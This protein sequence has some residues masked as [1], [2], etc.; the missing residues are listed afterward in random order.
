[1]EKVIVFA[2][3]MACTIP[4]A[5]LLCRLRVARKR[6]ISFGT[7]ALSAFVATFLWLAFVTQGDIYTIRFWQGSIPKPPDRV[8]MLKMIAFMLITCALPA[9]GVVHHYQR[10][11]KKDDQM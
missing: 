11:S 4:V 2:I 10:G 3:P 7:V 6:R 9:I 1:M 8:L 5:V